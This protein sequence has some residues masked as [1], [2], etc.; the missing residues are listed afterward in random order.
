VELSEVLALIRKG[1]IKD[2]KTVVGVLMVARD[3]V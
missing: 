1:E 2:G 3:T